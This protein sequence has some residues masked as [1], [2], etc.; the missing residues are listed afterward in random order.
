MRRNWLRLTGL[1]VG[2][3]LAFGTPA[4]AWASWTI[5]SVYFDSTGGYAADAG[6]DTATATAGWT[7]ST[8]PANAIAFYATASAAGTAADQQ[9]VAYAV[10][11]GH[12]SRDYVSDSVL[13]EDIPVT[14]HAAIDSE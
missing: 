6:G 9:R 14:V 11:Y 7:F 10:A 12:V 8:T 13:D 4:R 3:C 5:S 2:L 1:T